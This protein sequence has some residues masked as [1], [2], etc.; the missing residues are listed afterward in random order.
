MYQIV[1]A[2]QLRSNKNSVRTFL[3]PNSYCT[4]FP[5]Y[6]PF[7]IS[8]ENFLYFFSYPYIFSTYAKR[9]LP[10]LHL[11]VVHTHWLKL[12]N[13]QLFR[14]VSF[15]KSQH[16]APYFLQTLH[17]ICIISGLKNL[18]TLINTEFIYLMISLLGLRRNGYLFHSVVFRVASYASILE[19]HIRPSCLKSSS[20]AFRQVQNLLP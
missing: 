19:F 3:L 16:Y 18:Q 11:K 8:A 17:N 13:F 6:K 5:Y 20:S 7:F 14:I 2:L 1:V 15:Y 4:H 9:P 10:S 12:F